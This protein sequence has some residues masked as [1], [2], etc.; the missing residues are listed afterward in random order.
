MVPLAGFGSPLYKPGTSG[1][2]GALEKSLALAPSPAR[3]LTTPRTLESP[4]VCLPVHACTGP[5]AVPAL[6]NGNRISK[7]ITAVYKVNRQDKTPL[8]VELAP[9]GPLQKS[10]HFQRGRHVTAHSQ[11]SGRA[12]GRSQSQVDEAEGDGLIS[13]RISFRHPGPR[14][15]LSCLVY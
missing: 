14:L 3:C 8:P 7:L 9:R 4:S 12:Q 6:P 5:R 13:F 11:H 15:V 2:Q 10:G 1:T